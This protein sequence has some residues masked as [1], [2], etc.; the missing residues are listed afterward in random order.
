MSVKDRFIAFYFNVLR[1]SELW[2]KMHFTVENSPW[3]REA[4]V[5]THTDMVV[6]HYVSLCQDEWDH[7]DMLGAFAVAFHD[8]GKPDAEETVE[9][10]ERG[11]YRRY[12][13]HEQM[14]QRIWED[15]A[16]S[17]Y[18]MLHSEF[19]FEPNDLYRVGWV[20][21][22]HLPY[23]IKK[24]QKRKA[25]RHT[26]L[27]LFGRDT[28]FV[29]CLVADCWGRISDDHETKKETVYDWIRE[30]QTIDVSDLKSK[31]ELSLDKVCY[32]LIGASGSGKS[33]SSRMHGGDMDDVEI[34]SMDT[35]RL[36]WYPCDAS[37]DKEEYRSAFEQ[38][39][40][41][42]EFSSKVHAHF[43]GLMSDGCD[44]IYVD[45][46]NL[47]T[48]RRNFYVTAARSKGY[49]VVAVLFPI[50]KAE[51]LSRV[52]TRSDK[53]VPPGAVAGHYDSLQ[54]PSYVDFDDVIVTGHNLPSCDDD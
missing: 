34:H 5:E 52:E 44:I 14:S 17:N 29:N 15:W 13:G 28:V 22:H 26:V 32:V 35:L 46:T 41:D 27:R 11:V 30:Y 23:G 19:G 53:F 10:E 38:A 39:C 47:S 1:H 33:T 24:P 18:E 21:Q 40:E 37:D 2:N 7:Y 6:M 12:H 25:L 42:P 4:N 20:I 3:H 43:H 51:L 48:K 31:D 9:S 36:E 16:V 45:N 49:T 8:T 50:A 54:L